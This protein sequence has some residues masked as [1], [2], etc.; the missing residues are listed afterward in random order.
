[1]PIDIGGWWLS[2]DRGTLQK[3]QIPS[4]AILPPHGFAVFFESQFTNRNIAAIPFALSS[5][6]D[7]VVLSAASNN[8]LTGYRTSVKFGAAD[9]A[10][11]FGRYVTS[12]GR[13]EFVAM[14]A[15]TLGMDDPSSVQQFR[16]G[17]GASNA[18][19]RVGPVVI[20]EIM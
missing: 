4:P 11:S 18:Y 19:P 6:G 8:A 14:S 1:Q 3:F 2:D 9:N 10:V 16:T 13:E 12:D 17:T 7:E 5:H 15:H 20:S